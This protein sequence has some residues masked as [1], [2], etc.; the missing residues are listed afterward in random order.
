MPLADR[1]IFA[2]ATRHGRSLASFPAGS[3]LG[4]RTLRGGQH[5]GIGYWVDMAGDRVR[6]AHRFEGGQCRV[7]DRTQ[8]MRA[9]RSEYAAA[10]PGGCN[11][12]DDWVRGCFV[13]GRRSEKH[14]RIGMMRRL[15]Y[16]GGS[17]DLAD[18]ASIHHRDTI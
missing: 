17:S 18:L 12:A 2:S 9:A 5:R 1:G 10:L 6:F 8:L 4:I 11:P 14:P 3:M 13:I 15:Q 7:A 16:L